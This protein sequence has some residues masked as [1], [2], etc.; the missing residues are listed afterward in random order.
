MDGH[1]PYG[2]RVRVVDAPDDADFEHGAEG[3]I[4]D[5]IDYVGN[6]PWVRLDDGNRHVIAISELEVIGAA[7]V[8]AGVEADVAARYDGLFKFRDVSIRIPMTDA[9]ADRIVAT[10]LEHLAD[11]E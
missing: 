1:I 3:V 4:D 7:D 5:G 2:T 8:E 11:A 10:L 9:C 6:I